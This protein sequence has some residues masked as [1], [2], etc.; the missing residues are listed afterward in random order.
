MEQTVGTRQRP[1]EASSSHVEPAPSDLAD[2]LVDTLAPVQLDAD[3]SP[4]RKPEPKKAEDDSHSGVLR[5]KLA[6]GW[7]P[8][9]SVV[10]PEHL[11]L[12]DIGIPEPAKKSL[13]KVNQH[14]HNVFDT[15]NADT[16]NISMDQY[17]VILDKLPGDMTPKQFLD[18]FLKDPNG[19]AEGDKGLLG[20]ASAL[21]NPLADDS[22]NFAYSSAFDAAN[23]FE[24]KD[25]A[26]DPDTVDI[27]DMYHID[28]PGDD[29][30][31][32]VVDSHSDDEAESYSATVA[33]MTD[34]ET[35]LGTDAPK[36]HP[37]SGRRQFGIDKA[38]G[39]GYRF[40]TR[41]VDRATKG[42]TGAGPIDLATHAGQTADW[43]SLMG[44]VATKYGG[45]RGE[46]D[47]LGLPSYGGNRA[48]D[49]RD[50]TKSMKPPTPKKP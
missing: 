15:A 7:T 44:A 32:M 34:D 27:G 20:L 41:G 18:A 42:T 48:V 19:F 16:D 13:E 2:S 3:T 37:V 25:L 46:K 33:T 4:D 26:G 8:D 5:D 23:E 12:M 47:A 45:R 39:G 49:P 17:S 29:G 14:I 28:I 30:D 35:L 24:R 6:A 22:Q 11:A 38:E 43:T 36:D 9:P 50:I 40:Y 10:S 21:I 31:V 1:V